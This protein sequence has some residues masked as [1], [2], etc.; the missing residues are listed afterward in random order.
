MQ[1]KTN[2]HSEPTLSFVTG[3][4]ETGQLVRAFDWSATSL[5]SIKDW[6]QSLKTSVGIV[7]RS[8]VPMVMLWGEEG[9]MIY[10][11]AYSIFAGGRHPQLLGSKVREGW[12]EVANFNDNMMKV[13]LRGGTL[14][15]KDQELSLYRHG[16]AERVWMNLDYSP[17]LDESGEP[18]GVIAIVV[19]TT[20]RVLAD[21]RAASSA[22]ERER[23]EAALRASES[24]FRTF[25]QAMPNH[26]WTAP[27]NGAIDWFNNRVFEY[28]GSTQTQLAGAGWTDIVH[29]EDLPQTALRWSAS[30]DSGEP[31]ETEFRLRRADGRYRWHIAR[32]V[33]IREP[34]GAL[35]RWIGTNTDIHDQKLT[36]EALAH[37]NRTLEQQVAARIR[38]R[39]EIWRVSQDML[40]I[41]GIDGIIRAA[42][43]AWTATL[44]YAVEDLTGQH[45][46]SFVDPEDVEKTYAALA[47]ASREV[48][49]R[50]ENRYRHKD[51]SWR[52]I[53]WTAAHSGDLVYCVAR[54]V[55]E[56]RQREKEFSE[57]QERLRQSQKMEAVGQLTGGLAHDFNNLLTGIS[58]SLELL[59]TRVAQGR[60]NDLNRYL[61]A[62]QSA[63]K[64]AAAL[65]HRLLAFSR[66][67][68]LDPQATDVNR[69]VNDMTELIRR[70]VGPSITLEVIGAAGLWKSLVD[71][72]QLENALLNLCINARDAMPHGGRLTVE[73][74]N[75]HLDERGAKE[76]A[77]S[78]GHY[79]SLCVSDNGSGMTPEV[80]AR[81]FDP[82][83]TTKPLGEGTGLGLSMVYGFAQQSGGQVR[84]Y[85]EI[86]KGSMLCIYLPRFAG[87]QA[88]AERGP[89]GSGP[90]RAKHSETVLIV[91]DE[92]TVR[93]LVADVLEELGYNIMQAV[94]GK[95]GLAILE[96]KH[97]IDLLVTD[98][99]L[100]GGMNGRQLADAG[101][102]LRPT[103]KI[104]FITGYA[105]NAVIGDGHLR[106][107]M[108]VLTKPF[109]V[110]ELSS[111]VNG[112]IATE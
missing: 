14:A 51:G 96:S 37:L 72:N 85:S 28:S 61:A 34:G 89:G 107:G 106:R 40:L 4:G 86:G 50:F 36:A 31:Y 83:F 41:I 57:A 78:A 18:A 39:E 10:N 108:H 103:L 22:G 32:A 76:R 23:A 48:L 55:T 1:G 73:T 70:T 65:T 45:F 7:L 11:D 15:Y 27:A 52:D 98:V 6:P 63:A 79:I 59:E 12:P 26:V 54:D 99:G 92:P 8:S 53:A 47:L 3:G 33:P 29:P 81:A 74:A 88:I 97:R 109:T 68:T 94:D 42:N 95:S 60:I 66:R 112:I 5:G 35:A 69:L 58:G 17:I 111:R 100:P 13:V 44:G 24:Q 102:T 56:D 90:R 2:Y 77:L 21:R 67:Q 84:I 19:E 82:F 93:M 30:L 16:A 20:E 71:Q 104:L 43:P 25:A 80:V 38:E 87:D 62:A 64:R 49:P 91:D 110:E 105:E 46:D 9:V 75:R 101:I